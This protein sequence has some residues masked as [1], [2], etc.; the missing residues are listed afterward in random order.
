MTVELAPGE[1]VAFIPQCGNPDLI[2]SFLKTLKEA[3]Q[4]V[5]APTRKTILEYYGKRTRWYPLVILGT[6]IGSISPIAMGGGKDDG[7]MAW[8]DSLALLA[9]P[10]KE[11]S[12]LVAIGEEL[13]HAYLLASQDPT[14]ISDPP[15]EDQESPEYKAWK[16]AREEA[17]M[18]T[19]AQWPFDHDEHAKLIAW[20]QSKSA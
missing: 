2:D 8:F 7:F 12:I 4:K 3:W 9:M 6:R 1:F 11:A 20:A 15:N 18:K 5:P 13:A 17:M 14:H 10:G 16:N 19:F